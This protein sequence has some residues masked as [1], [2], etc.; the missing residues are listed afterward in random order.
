VASFELTGIERGVV[1][2]INISSGQRTAD[3]LDDVIQ[4]LFTELLRFHRTVDG[5]APQF[6]LIGLEK[7]RAVLKT[8]E[9][10]LRNCEIAIDGLDLQWPSSESIPTLVF[11]RLVWLDAV[12]GAWL[13]TSHAS[14]G[15]LQVL[16]LFLEL[17]LIEVRASRGAASHV[18]LVGDEFDRNLHPTAATAVLGVLAD[19]LTEIPGATAIVS[20][21]NVASASAP[22]IRSCERI[23]ARRDASGFK[24]L[25]SMDS[26]IEAISDV[27]GVAALDALRLKRLHI[28]VEGT[29]DE[30][31]ISDLLKNQ[32]PEL[33]DIEIVNARGLYGWSG[34]YA[35]WLRH[36]D[37]PVLLVHDKR[38]Q[39]LEENWRLCQRQVEETGSL[40]PWE[41]SWFESERGKAEYR[42]SRGEW[43]PG[44]GELLQ[45]LYL[46]RDNIFRGD[47][48]QAKRV[49]I[50][51]LSCEDI[52]DLLPIS[53]FENAARSYSCWEDAHR[54]FRKKS[55]KG[56]SKKFKKDLDINEKTV[57]S[58]LSNN[59]DHVVPELGRLLGEIRRLLDS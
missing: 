42:S 35:N 56:S 18:V 22:A 34:L 11:P 33:N 5:E 26:S 36:L 38:N 41:R 31:V 44:D 2:S 23:I 32:V 52:V 21:H 16:T 49:H 8:A 10:R 59:Q 9:V 57:R 58:A 15:Q 7:L 54:E 39:E 25:K 29:H 51:G 37:A 43:R 6:E 19:L 20:T 28:V 13:E 3:R 45:V 40:K 24:Y 1:R 46:L 47:N 50:F 17:G 27:L 12:S 48:L 4:S 53:E 14:D 30:L 55:P